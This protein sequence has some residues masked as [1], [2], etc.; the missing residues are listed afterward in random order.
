VRQLRAI[1]FPAV[2]V[3]AGCGS[4]PTAE[5][6]LEAERQEIIAN[7]HREAVAELDRKTAL[8]AKP[9]ASNPP[10]GL[11]ACKA[12]IAELMSQ[13]PSIMTGKVL[14]PGRYEVSY[15]RANDGE[16]WTY[17]CRATDQEL[18]W[19]TLEGGSQGPW[20]GAEQVRY[21]TENNRLVLTLKDLNGADYV[22]AFSYPKLRELD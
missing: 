6:R 14:E 11:S 3:L 22:S 19:A 21:Q 20:R 7:A 1:I 4:E 12:T 8:F 13:S 15:R 5:E 17:R 9:L 18:D 16:R 2:I 10:A